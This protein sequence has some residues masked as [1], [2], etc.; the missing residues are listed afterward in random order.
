MKRLLVLMIVLLS[1][2]MAG[3]PAQPKQRSLLAIFAHTDDWLFAGPALARYAREGVTVRIVSVTRGDRG[4]PWPQG[5]PEGDELARVQ[6]EEMRCASRELGAEPPVVLQFSD[7]ELGK[8]IR[9]PWKETA[10]VREELLKLIL[11]HN[12]DV[13]ITFGPE[14]GYGHP[15]H[16]LVGAIV[17]EIVQQQS[18]PATRLAYPGIAP[19]AFPTDLTKNFPPVAPTQARFLT[20]RVSYSR[21]DFEVFRKALSCHKSQFPVAY[22]EGVLAALEKTW[23]GRIHFRPAFGTQRSDDLF[24]LK[25][26]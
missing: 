10:A 25:P 16:R 24:E 18:R 2:C 15:D 26:M 4:I 14:G 11:E 22:L 23:A 20:V 21:A 1:L 13:V 6:G 17:T 9:P 12:P 19:E 7:G 5:V 3:A 8:R